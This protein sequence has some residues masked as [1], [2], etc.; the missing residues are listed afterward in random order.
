MRMFHFVPPVP[1]E[2]GTLCR[3]QQKHSNAQRVML[4]QVPLITGFSTQQDPR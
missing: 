3:H 2:N 4:L 1:R